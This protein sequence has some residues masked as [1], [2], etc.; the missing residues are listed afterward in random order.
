MKTGFLIYAGNASRGTA[1]LVLRCGFV[2]PTA[3]PALVAAA[4]CPLACLL[5]VAMDAAP[6]PSAAD[7]ACRSQRGQPMAWAVKRAFLADPQVSGSQSVRV[8]QWQSVS[9]RR[10]VAVSQ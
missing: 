2:A 9:D 8:S 6:L 5:L 7:V 1:S 4:T 3:M 10:S